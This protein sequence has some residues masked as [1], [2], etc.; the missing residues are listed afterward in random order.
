M[1]GRGMSGYFAR[2]WLTVFR[3]ARPTSRATSWA[4][5]RSSVW[6]RGI[7]ENILQPC[8]Y[9]HTHHDIVRV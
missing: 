9:C 4:S 3:C 8:D 2:Y 1:T 7:S 6:T 5:I